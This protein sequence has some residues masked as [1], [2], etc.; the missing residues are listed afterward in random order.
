MMRWY[1]SCCEIVSVVLFSK[2]ERSISQDAPATYLPAAWGLGHKYQAKLRSHASLVFA[3]LREY[4]PVKQAG[5]ECI[6]R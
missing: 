1:Q 5:F 3:A 4:I 2:W 6:A